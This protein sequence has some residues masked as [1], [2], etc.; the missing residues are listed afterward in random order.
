MNTRVAHLLWEGS[1][2]Q[3]SASTY[4]QWRHHFEGGKDVTERDNQTIDGTSANEDVLWLDPLRCNLRD[5]SRNSW[6]FVLLGGVWT[7]RGLR[8]DGIP[9]RGTL[10]AGGP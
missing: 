2:K 4:R 7:R 10:Q 6:L 3:G 1:G 5:H 8:P 9:L